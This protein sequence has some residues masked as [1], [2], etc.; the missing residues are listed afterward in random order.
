MLDSL[1]EEV[2]VNMS[3]S[4]NAVTHRR[5]MPGIAASMV[6]APGVVNVMPAQV[7]RAVWGRVS[8]RFGPMLLA[9]SEDW[10]GWLDAAPSRSAGQPSGGL[11]NR[12]DWHRSDALA[13]ELLAHYCAAL[14]GAG[15]LRI[16][17]AATDFQL[18]V[19]SA[20]QLI[21]PGRAC[22][23]G[24]L[25]AAIGRP[26][27]ARAVGA[28]LAAN[29]VALFVP[30]HRVVPAA[31]GSGQFRWGAPLKQRLLAAEARHRCSAAMLLG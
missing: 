28:A 9:G 2:D 3:R 16:G 14:R 26:G 17:V 10:L 5:S 22:S 21:A 25:A 29:T 27:A 11:L 13:S 19:W 7:E 6:A 4:I 23:Y 31:G 8:T 20:A 24:E 18:E 15:Q 12:V 1:A 30:C